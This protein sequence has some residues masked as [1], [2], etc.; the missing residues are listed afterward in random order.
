M[1]DFQ[2]IEND[3][4]S[5][6]EDL[7]LWLNSVITEENM[8]IGELVYVLC[9]DEYL[10]K[11]NIQFLNHN[12]L[13]DVITFDYSGDKIISGD[14]LISTERVVE[15]S[16]IFNVNYLTELNRVMVHGLLHLLGYKDKNEQDANTM[17]EKENYYLNKFA[18]N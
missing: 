5:N 9:N 12:N 15:N 4:L 8:V 1:I 2:Y 14:I 18:N 10:L 6:T 7:N 11:K 3:K 13:T 16:K 17:R